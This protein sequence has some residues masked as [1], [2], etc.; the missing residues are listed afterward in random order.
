MTDGCVGGVY[1]NTVLSDSIFL[2]G[3]EVSQ[4]GWGT[5]RE[6]APPVW[7]SAQGDET[8]RE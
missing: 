8:D 4:V 7:E 6:V 5:G 2:C 3:P 1:L